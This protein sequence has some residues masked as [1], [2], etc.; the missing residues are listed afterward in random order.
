MQIGYFTERPYRWL[1]EELILKNRA[2]FA[3]SNRYFDREKAAE[4]LRVFRGGERG[5]LHLSG[6]TTHQDQ[7]WIGAQPLE[8]ERLY[9]V[10]GSDWELEPYG[11][12]VEAA[13]N[14]QPTYETPTIMREAIEEHLA[15]HN[16]VSVKMERLT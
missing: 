13:W 2:F 16:P 15:T 6:A 12:Y 5:L 10:A 1:P 8:P 4:R 9:S 3:I 14:L 11:G 7:V